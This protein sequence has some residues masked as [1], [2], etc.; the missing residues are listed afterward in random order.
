MSDS[1]GIAEPLGIDFY[2]VKSGETHYAKLEPTIAAYINSSDMGVNAS[3][4]QNF[5]W[6]LGAEWVN[7]VR[8]FRRD[9]VQ[10]S[11]LTA[12]NGG[13]KPTTV[14]VLYHLYGEQLQA[15]EEE[16]EENENPFE[17]Q[18]QRD[19][20]AGRKARKAP[21]V[22]APDDIA[23]L[24]DDPLDEDDDDDTP[25]T[26]LTPEEQAAADEIALAEMEAEEKAASEA[27]QIQDQ[28]K[29]VAKPEDLKKMADDAK[30][31]AAKP[32]SN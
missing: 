3:R 12:K 15:Y 4:G 21:T 19:V 28:P 9:R 1:N 11:I 8:N 27:K 18:Y 26:L 7:A 5:G 14:Q 29:E 2:N 24:V 17:E 31:K 6:K 13:Q 20:A 22:A 16:V 10:M 23:D 32:K 25:P 30:A